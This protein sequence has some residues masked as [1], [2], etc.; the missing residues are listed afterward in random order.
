MQ[1]AAR[2]SSRGIVSPSVRELMKGISRGLV[3][4]SL[5]KVALAVLMVGTLGA[6]VAGLARAGL[7]EPSC[8]EEDPSPIRVPRLAAAQDVQRNASPAPTA[9]DAPDIRGIWEVLYV[10]GTV[11][12]KRVGYAMPDRIARATDNTI[13]LPH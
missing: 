12:G 1:L 3:M 8:D 10:G 6:C 13:A 11:A 2:G 5:K 4:K 9:G 7:R